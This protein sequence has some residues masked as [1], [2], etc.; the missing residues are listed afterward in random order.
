MV[1][2]KFKF[3]RPPHIY[4]GAGTFKDVC[5]IVRGYGRSVLVLTGGSSL[6]A[7]GRLAGLLA[8][9]DALSI[10][11]RHVSINTEPFP[12]MIDEVVRG[13]R[14]VGVEVVLAVG[15]GSVLDAG[16]AVSA[17]LPTGEGVFDY[18]EGVGSGAV[19][20][21]VKVPFIAAPTTAG[22]GSEATKNAV[23][24]RVGQ[25]GFKK[26]LRHD[27]FVPDVAVVDPEL[28]L[29]C[30]PAI[31]AS[32]GLDAFTQLLESYVS[33]KA[34]VVTDSL[35]LGAL[36]LFK[37][38]L[39]AA[40]TVSPGDI[41]VRSALS[42]ASLISGITLANAG[43]G[44]VHGISSVI[45]AHFDIPH[46]VICGTLIGAATKVN[47][48]RLMADNAVDALKKFAAVGDLITAQ[49][50]NSSVESSLESLIRTIDNWVSALRMPLLSHYGVGQ[51]HLDMIASR[52]S[53][54]ESPVKLSN[55]DIMDILRQRL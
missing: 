47:I 15:G 43:L 35:A 36:E 20:S 9:L 27:N 13:C 25:D 41:V 33:T 14:D 28:T 53:N 5:T 49:S 55:A 54:K 42:Y 10:K 34:S 18:L 16:K 29:S 48:Q 44:V 17:M 31:T 46:G 7:S 8:D 32:C 37:D 50:G 45:S 2:L 23:I 51:Q 21:G 26:S 12:E 24:S 1:N 40:C 22:T 6:K 38:N 3:A 30:P 11:H 52:S 39:V 19:H 4:F